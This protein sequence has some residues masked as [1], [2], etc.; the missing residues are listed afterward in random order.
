MRVESPALTWLADID[1]LIQSR[2][3]HDK[4]HPILK[5][6]SVNRI[7]DSFGVLADIAICNATLE[8]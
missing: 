2:H 3:L 4:H 7:I 5:T 1:V 6:A 8:N